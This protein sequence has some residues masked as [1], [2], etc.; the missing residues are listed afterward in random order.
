MSPA[1]ATADSKLIVG[2]VAAVSSGHF[3]LALDRDG[4][5]GQVRGTQVRLA[6]DA[7][8]RV[9]EGERPSTPA[10]IEVRR[11]ATVLYDD[12]KGVNVAREVRLLGMLPPGVALPGGATGGG[13]TRPPNVPAGSV[14]RGDTWRTSYDAFLAEVEQLLKSGGPY[15]PA[16]ARF[17]GQRVTWD[18]EPKTLVTRPGRGTFLEIGFP[19]HRWRLR[20]GSTAFIGFVADQSG[21]RVTLRESKAIGAVQV[22]LTEGVLPTGKTAN[23]PDIVRV[24]FVLKRVWIQPIDSRE[25]PRLA[26]SSTLAIQA[27]SPRLVT[28]LDAQRPR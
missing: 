1:T 7:N 20:D 13:D 18:G 25:N 2:Y 28:T 14:A 22:P 6:L 19:Q 5:P 9:L 16:L 26:G 15:D 12:T 21:T 23:I 8:T 3:V 27:D 24:S 11:Q 10:A 4:Y 17:Q